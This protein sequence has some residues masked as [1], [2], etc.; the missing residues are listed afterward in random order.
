[1]NQW[2]SYETGS[3]EEL[4]EGDQVVIPF[5]MAAVSRRRDIIE[6]SIQAS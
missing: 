5:N 6:R 4:E 2:K 3:D 1:M